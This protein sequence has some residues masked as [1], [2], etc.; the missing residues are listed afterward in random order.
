MTS[1]SERL[2][3]RISAE[4]PQK[5]RPQVPPRSPEQAIL[6]DLGEFGSTGFSTDDSTEIPTEIPG[7]SKRQSIKKAEKVAEIKE[8]PQQEPLKTTSLIL[9]ASVQADIRHLCTL[10][11]ISYSAYFQ[12]CYEVLSDP[13]LKA[14]QEQVLKRAQELRSERRGEGRS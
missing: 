1:A 4:N 12:A 6:G 7:G 9:R 14:I 2:K 13:E 11:S 8:E 5:S 3:R 10:N